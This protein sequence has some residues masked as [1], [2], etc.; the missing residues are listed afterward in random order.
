MS[1]EDL[2]YNGKLAEQ[3]QKTFEKRGFAFSFFTTKGEAA[4]FIM[5]SIKKEDTIA[6]GGSRSVEELGVINELRKGDYPNFLD[7]GHPGLSPDDKLALQQK[8]FAADVYLSGSNAV[9]MDG[10]LVNIDKVGNRVA[11]MLYGP[12]KVFLVFGV[13]KICQTRDD[14]LSRVSNKAAVL[15]NIRFNN[16]TPCVKALKCLDC[17]HEK[18]ICSYTT[19]IERCFPLERIHLVFVGEHLGF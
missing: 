4:K 9:G 6:F 19:I 8:S 10:S 17:S 7:R 5:G 1:N 3:L 18:R 12:E 11:A 2:I 16:D 15:N 14:A 13:N